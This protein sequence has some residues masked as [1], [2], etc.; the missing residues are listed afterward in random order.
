V[1]PCRRTS[2]FKRE[3]DS[4]QSTLDSYESGGFQISR[5]A[6]VFSG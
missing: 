5:N 2:R 4:G 1:R 3:I 6:A